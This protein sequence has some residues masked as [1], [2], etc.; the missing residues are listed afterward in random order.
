MKEFTS[1]ARLQRH[2]NYKTS[3]AVQL[4]RD[5]IFFEPPPGINSSSQRT[6]V[7]FPMPVLRTQGPHRQWQVPYAQEWDTGI[8][9]DVEEDLLNC[10]LDLRR[11]GDFLK[12]V[13]AFK[14]V[15]QRRWYSTRELFKTFKHFHGEMR[16]R[17]EELREEE[18][19]PYSILEDI[20]V[21][22][23]KHL[24]SRWFFTEKE[25]EQL[26]GA[27]D[28]REAAWNFSC[29][30]D[31]ERRMERDGTP[32]RVSDFD[33]LSFYISSQV[34]SDVETYKMR[35]LEYR[36]RTVTLESFFLWI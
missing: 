2:L 15:L 28:L 31:A 5:G 12:A 23:D 13:E 9:D 26:P 25:C 19:L 22:V 3:C 24:H 34:S 10:A 17:W 33:S 21:W 35:F 18:N 4:R 36:F 1:E 7:D 14:S 11:G 16:L 30:K 6:T 20:L 27:E 8:L 32:T 29:G